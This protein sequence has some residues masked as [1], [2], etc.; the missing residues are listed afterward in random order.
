MWWCSL[1][2]PVYLSG[3]LSEEVTFASVVRRWRGNRE[4]VERCR[5]ASDSVANEGANFARLAKGKGE[6]GCSHV[7]KPARRQGVSYMVVMQNGRVGSTYLVELMNQHPNVTCLAENLANAGTV[8]EAERWANLEAYFGKGLKPNG[9]P[10]TTAIRGAKQKFGSVAPHLDHLAALNVRMICLARSNFVEHAVSTVT[11]DAHQLACG[12]HQV[13]PSGPCEN[14]NMSAVARRAFWDDNNEPAAGL[15]CLITRKAEEL[16]AFHQRCASLNAPTLWLDY[17]DLMCDREST[18][19]KLAAFLDLPTAPGWPHDTNSV[20]LT[21]SF[22]SFVPGFP[23]YL[24]WANLQG[25]GADFFV[26]ALESANTC[27][28]T[29]GFCL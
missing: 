19:M 16:F 8:P 5:R 13:G 12:N 27:R 11:G 1:I 7:I 18:V 28:R 10:V 3:S 15:L 26:N 23:D 17:N 20:K 24:D 29:P 14:Y 9:E 4:Y 6:M 21:N 2:A 22:D 25:L